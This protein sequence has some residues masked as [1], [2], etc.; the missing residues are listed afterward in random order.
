MEGAAFVLGL[1]IVPFTLVSLYLLT[2]TNV[3]Y[4]DNSH[5]REDPQ[6]IFTKVLAASGLNVNEHKLYIDSDPSPNAYTDYTNVYIHV[7]M[8]EFVKSDDELAA[9]IGHELGHIYDHKVNGHEWQGHPS[10]ARSDVLGI[11]FANKAGYK[12]C[13]LG[14]LFFRIFN[15][16]GDSYPNSHPQRS[17]RAFDTACYDRL[18]ISWRN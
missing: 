4:V 12:G 17:E 13:A 16:Y 2:H 6:V 11:Q 8:L 15:T 3:V 10:E 18:D 1:F 7:G 14:E 9:I 5:L